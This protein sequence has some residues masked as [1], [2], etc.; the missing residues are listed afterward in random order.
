MLALS[1]MTFCQVPVPS[2]RK[3]VQ[4]KDLF[5][6]TW[7]LDFRNKLGPNWDIVDRKTRLCAHGLKQVECM[8]FTETPAPTAAANANRLFLAHAAHKEIHAHQMDVNS[9]FLHAPLT[10]E[11]YMRPLPGIP[12]LEV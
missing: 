10:K 8:D 9:A 7:K 6:L 3:Y 12:P 4:K 5:L 2:Q 1:A 11:L